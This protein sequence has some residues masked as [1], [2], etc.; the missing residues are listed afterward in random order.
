MML[1]VISKV[2]PLFSRCCYV[3]LLLY[4]AYYKPKLIK[5]RVLM[6]FTILESHC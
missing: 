6:P 5:L 2:A 4:M 1:N 3:V